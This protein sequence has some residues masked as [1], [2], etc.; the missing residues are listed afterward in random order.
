LG[1]P[2]QE[3]LQIDGDNKDLKAG[4]DGA[5]KRGRKAHLGAA[6]AAGAGSGAGGAAK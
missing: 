4:F 3:G 1:G 2:G 5:I 6:G